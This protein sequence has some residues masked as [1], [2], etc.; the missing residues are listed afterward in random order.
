MEVSGFL[1]VE[2]TGFRESH[3]ALSAGSPVF[4]QSAENFALRS[5]RRERQNK[6]MQEGGPTSLMATSIPWP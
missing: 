1:G 3:K 4:C 2:G 6:E 5:E